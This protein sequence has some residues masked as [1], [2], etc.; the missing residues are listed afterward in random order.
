LF[1]VT[2][3]ADEVEEDDYD[4]SVA[5]AVD[6]VAIGNHLYYFDTCLF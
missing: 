4:E 1:L 3:V 2:H 6:S 5:H